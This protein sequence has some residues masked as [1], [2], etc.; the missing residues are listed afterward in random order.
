MDIFEKLNKI[1]KETNTTDF[2]I[3]SCG[4]ENLLITGSFNF[5][6]YHEVEV[7]FQEVEYIDLLASFDNP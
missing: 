2:R 1:S 7:K 6:Y 4:G 3:D 5:C